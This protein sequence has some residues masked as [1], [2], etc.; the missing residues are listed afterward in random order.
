MP[1][2]ATP[3]TPPPSTDADM[4]PP[5]SARRGEGLFAES[6]PRSYTT[7]RVSDERES[8]FIDLTT[9]SY[10]YADPRLTSRTSPP[11]PLSP[12]G[13]TTLD[14]EHESDSARQVTLEPLECLLRFQASQR[15]QE[16]AELTRFVAFS[17]TRPAAPSD[18]AQRDALLSATT[19]IELGDALRRQFTGPDSAAVIADLRTELQVAQQINAYLTR[20]LDTQSAESADLQGQLKVMTLERDR[21][22]DLSKQST[23]FS[24]SLRKSVAELE[25][26][27]TSVRAVSDAEIAAAFRHA[28]D[29]KRQVLD[30]DQ[31]IATLCASIVDRDR[32][33]ATLQG[34]ATKHFTQL[35]ESARLLTDGGSQPLRHAREVITHQRAVILRQ[36]RVIARQGSIPVHDPHMAVAAAGGLDVPGLSPTLFDS[37]FPGEEGHEEV[38]DLLAGNDLGA[39]T[40]GEWLRVSALSS[41]RRRPRSSRCS[42]APRSTTVVSRS[43][44]PASDDVFP[45]FEA[46]SPAEDVEFDPLTDG[47]L[48]STSPPGGVPVSGSFD[49]SMTTA[50]SGPV[51]AT[52]STAVTTVVS[53]APTLDP[54]VVGGSSSCELT[55]GSAILN[56]A[57]TAPGLAYP[58][59]V[60]ISIPV[61]SA[62]D[63]SSRSVAVSTIPAA[64]SAEF[65]A[66]TPISAAVPASV[67]CVVAAS[68]TTPDS[69]R[70]ATSAS[71]TT[72]APSPPSSVAT[73]APVPDLAV[74]VVSTS[75]SA[76]LL[77]LTAT[78]TTSSIS[79]V[80]SAD[81]ADL[82]SS[83]AG[84]SAS[85]PDSAGASASAPDSARAS[86][87]T[88]NSAGVSATTPDSA[89]ASTST[90]DSA[91]ASASAL[92]SAAPALTASDSIVTKVV[93]S[94]SAAPA[95][96]VSD[97]S[98]AAAPAVLRLLDCPRRQFARQSHD[99][100]LASRVLMTG[101]GVSST[102]TQSAVPTPG[103]GMVSPSG[104]PRRAS[105]VNAARLSSHYLGELKVSD[106]VALGLGD[107][108]E[109]SP[110][111]AVHG[112]GTSAQPLELY[113][114]SSEGEPEGTVVSSSGS[115][116]GR[117]QL[118]HRDGSVV[119]GPKT[120]ASAFAVPASD[121]D[122][123]SEDSDHIPIW[124]IVSRMQ[125]G[126]TATRG[127]FQSY[128]LLGRTP[129]SSPPA[130]EPTRAEAVQ[131]PRSPLLGKKKRQAERLAP[132][133]DSKHKNKH[134]H[135]RKHKHK[136]RESARAGHACSA[137]DRGSSKK[138]KR[139]APSDSA[140]GS[141]PPK[142]SRLARSSLSSA[143]LGSLPP[144]D[145][146]SAT[147]RPAGSTSSSLT[148]ATR[149]SDPHP[150]AHSVPA[151][152]AALRVPFSTLQTR[153]AQAASRDSRIT[154]QNARLHE[155]SQQASSSYEEI[156]EMY[157]EW[158]KY[159]LNRKRRSDALRGLMTSISDGLFS[160]VMKVVDGVPAPDV[161]AEPWRTWWL[162]DPAIHPYNTC[163]RARKV[164]F[165]PFAPTEME[166]HVV[167][168]A[169][170]D[171]VNLTESDPPI[172]SSNA[173][174][175]AN[176]S[177]IHI[178]ESFG[179]GELGWSASDSAATARHARAS[180]D[181]HGETP[182][183][184][185][186]GPDSPD[187]NGPA[188]RGSADPAGRASP[189][190]A[191]ASRSPRNIDSAM[192]LLASEASS[193]TLAATPPDSDSLVTL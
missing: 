76:A 102:S 59:Q 75:D 23:A 98:V 92:V 61:C 119:S 154:P 87:S 32:A 95:T 90:P 145:V 81:I 50:T 152:P 114:S 184:S 128:L 130:S 134:K 147:V 162:T 47:A 180:Q 34:V 31:E 176:R 99:D 123:S 57:A 109:S 10:V 143:S 62:V 12:P 189:D 161:D 193:V 186:F 42:V 16:L 6:Q 113:G 25:A 80:D 163:F 151:L 172:R 185:L 71:S 103:Q 17:L 79:T 121:G 117:E 131:R 150:G 173:P 30:R 181:D 111:S 146:L 153:A 11:R 106:R 110:D 67:S 65:V 104:R 22:L 35:Q 18:R 160:A 115:T 168:A 100:G 124:D 29:S 41:K 156:A 135:K 82:A 86:V 77:V 159:K 112:E 66:C 191:S 188:G 166:S 183:D 83:S 144:T 96:S 1:S 21:L 108:A 45:D 74:S 94:S 39:V 174:T 126:Q 97:P 149:I 19:I 64:N 164:D 73:V 116:S 125:S 167:E 7:P 72:T 70:A 53:A 24:A 190:R 89:V 44:S 137:D 40:D 48:T 78:S 36:K 133:R 179:P 127:K 155:L 91:E 139:S 132:E 15:E 141:R 101:S 165:L 140:D 192:D 37:S 187:P 54:A 105:A 175:C 2:Q 60:T 178:F 122:D 4:T 20:R 136:L 51:A 5:P 170:V 118:G 14:A 33:Y 107:S 26:Q 177:G 158:F 49:S 56:S 182:S 38:M 9:S 169:V 68:V 43:A 148:V 28:D 85:A 27:V 13:D 58:V 52:S 171:D 157:A 120:R 84:A 138:A 88:P 55:T 129:P 63:V 3:V 8:L 142:K 69:T 93:T 46:G